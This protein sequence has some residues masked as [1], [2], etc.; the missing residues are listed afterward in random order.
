MSNRDTFTVFYE[1]E[2]VE[3]EGM[4][5]GVLELPKENPD[6]PSSQ[7]GSPCTPQS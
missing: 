7:A 1:A 5:Q 6:S 2:N 4:D 3:G